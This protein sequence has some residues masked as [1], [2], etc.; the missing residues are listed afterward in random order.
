MAHLEQLVE[1]LQGN[2]T[3]SHV[4]NLTQQ[5][6]EM[7]KE[8]DNLA[9]LLH[10]IRKM[11]RETSRIAPSQNHSAQNL[12]GTTPIQIPGRSNGPAQQEMWNYSIKSPA[13]DPNFSVLS[14]LT[15]HRDSS[16]TSLP[17]ELSFPTQLH[18][19]FNTVNGFENVAHSGY[20]MQSDSGLLSMQP[21]VMK[22][23]AM[24]SPSNFMN[25]M[26]R[27]DLFDPPPIKQFTMGP[28]T[29]PPCECTV[30]T[31]VYPRRIK[32]S[33]WNWLNNHLATITPE[34]ATVVAGEDYVLRDSIAIQAVLYGWNSV[35]R[36]LTQYTS[37]K[38]LRAADE[39]LFLCPDVERLAILIM[40]SRLLQ[41]HVASPAHKVAVLP[42]WYM[43][44]LV[45]PYTLKTSS[46]LATEYSYMYR[47]SQT[48]IS[49]SYAMEFFAW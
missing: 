6:A 2:D 5:L 38:L 31:Y 24:I 23:T 10:N 20:G 26:P 29:D 34:M 27:G 48:A 44:R 8:R 35:E 32:G 40:V 18:S 36:Y 12:K 15:G 46:D 30:S 49:H 41:R 22:N 4:E 9:K 16:F 39:L 17:R 19:S 42:S 33:K 11:T 21:F 14:G 1:N 37:L 7:G 28:P 47:P 3:S 25:V 13:A 43:S 45:S